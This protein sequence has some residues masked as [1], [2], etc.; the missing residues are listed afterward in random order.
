M[1]IFLTYFYC[2]SG[3]IDVSSLKKRWSPVY[4]DQL[5]EKYGTNKEELVAFFG[6][7][8]DDLINENLDA[9]VSLN[10]VTISSPMNSSITIITLSHNIAYILKLRK[11]FFNAIFYAIFNPF[12]NDS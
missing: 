4:R 3:K 8:R 5:I 12:I 11:M 7:V 1:A 9:W 10:Q 6:K 2:T